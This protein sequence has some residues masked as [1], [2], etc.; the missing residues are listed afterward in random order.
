MKISKKDFISCRFCFMLSYIPSNINLLAMQHDSQETFVLFRNIYCLGFNEFHILPWE[1]REILKV[2]ELQKDSKNCLYQ[3]QKYTQHTHEDPRIRVC[4][5]IK[6]IF[7]DPL[8]L[9]K[10]KAKINC[11][12]PLQK[13]SKQTDG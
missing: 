11:S 6:N 4:A 9:N 12:T 3:P 5:E 8:S 2:R 1:K 7:I 13:Y 10:P